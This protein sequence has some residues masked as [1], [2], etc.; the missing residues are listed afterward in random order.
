MRDRHDLLGDLRGLT[1]VVDA[2][3]PA[4][5]GSLLVHPEL[6]PETPPVAEPDLA[7]PPP[8]PPTHE[9]DAPQ[10]G[11][12]VAELDRP[13]MAVGA[14]RLGATDRDAVEVPDVG[15][16]RGLEGMGMNGDEWL[17]AIGRA[18]DGVDE[19]D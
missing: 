13:P 2:E 18:L 4:L 16:A 17:D 12:R 11:G 19:E 7:H 9:V 14:P 8:R 3:D 15:A 10:P 1:R 5:L 6:Q